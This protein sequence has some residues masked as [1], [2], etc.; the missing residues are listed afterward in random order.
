[1][2]EERQLDFSKATY[3]ETPMGIF[4]SAGNWF[5]TTVDRIQSYAP[6][7]LE[8]YSFEQLIKDAEVW[9]RSSDGLAI[10]LFMLFLYLYG[11]LPAAIAVLIFLP[12]WHLN[13]SA[14][15]SRNMSRLLKVFDSEIVLILAGVL[16]LSWMGIQEQYTDL[17][18][19]LIFFLVLKF[20]WLRKGVDW[21]YHRGRGGEPTLGDRVMKMLVIRYAMYEG[22]D[23]KDVK[24]MESDILEVI[25]KKNRR[26]K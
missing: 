6:G 14:F 13:K 26:K 8:K 7:L 11:V 1:M 2:A 21:I 25:D 3:V 17:V 4:T 24:K 9:I 23:V 19:G 22:L 5:H 20:G 18:V 16:V 10:V 15:I 12:V